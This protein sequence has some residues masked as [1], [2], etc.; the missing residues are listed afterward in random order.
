MTDIIQRIVCDIHHAITNELFDRENFPYI[1]NDIYRNLHEKGENYP[2]EILMSE[3][4]YE[5]MEKRMGICF[6]SNDKVNDKE[7][8]E[9]VSYLKKMHVLA[10]IDVETTL[11]SI[12]VSHRVILTLPGMRR[13]FCDEMMHFFQNYTKDEYWN[14]LDDAEKEKTINTVKG[15][16]YGR[17]FED[18]IL[19][20]CMCRAE[21]EAEESGVTLRVYRFE[22]SRQ[23]AG[24]DSPWG[25][26]DMVIRAS[27]GGW[28]RYA[29]FEAKCTASAR[30]ADRHCQHL[31]K[32]DLLRAA[33]PDGLVALRA[34]LYN[35]GPL[36]VPGGVSAIPGPI[37]YLN[38]SQFLVDVARHGLLALFGAD[39]P[40]SRLDAVPEDGEAPLPECMAAEGADSASRQAPVFP[41][42]SAA[43]GPA[44]KEK[45][46]S[47]TADEAEEE[48]C[49]PS[50]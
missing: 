16:F 24:P 40:R 31:R 20:E 50:F 5:Y 39:R 42:S 45:L 12:D 13:Q 49:G 23:D 25:E 38:A 46:S 10:D 17:I 41:A 36:E 27:C 26:F 30:M 48:A 32:E 28:T 37:R 11:P 29:L 33:C 4:F 18:C 15:A 7:K 6:S 35:G 2:A 9:I 43:Q 14:C 44:G 22:N 34:V 1:V 19:Y 8:K 47:W 21:K 3:D